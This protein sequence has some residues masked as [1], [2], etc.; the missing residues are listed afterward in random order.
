M[1]AVQTSKCMMGTLK[2]PPYWGA[3]MAQLVKCPALDLSSGH[4]L[5][6]HGIEP[7]TGLCADSV[8][9]A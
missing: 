2:K 4:D 3:W 6:V 9:P 8:E 1:S 5:M 7:C